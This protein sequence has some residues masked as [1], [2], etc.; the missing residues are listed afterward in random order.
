LELPEINYLWGSD[1]F[2]GYIIDV[3]VFHRKFLEKRHQAVL[4]FFKS[5]FRVLSIYTNNKDKMIREMSKSTGLQKDVILM[6]LKKI[7]WFDLQENCSRQF[8]ITTRVGL[9]ANDGLINTIIA[10][11]DVMI[12]MNRLN[13]DPLQGNP[14]L[15]TNSKIIEELSKSS[16]ASPMAKDKDYAMDFPPLD[17]QGW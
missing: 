15:I 8:G 5:Y 4:D 2:A 17:D 1:K 13:K 11:T 16:I 3:F 12:R 14:Y 7:D 9:P 6:L 10:C